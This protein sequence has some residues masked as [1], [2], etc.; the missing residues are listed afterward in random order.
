M[1][2]CI[3]STA[4]F[5]GSKLSYHKGGLSK[6]Y[7]G[8][9]VRAIC[10]L[11]AMQNAKNHLSSSIACKQGN[12]VH[13][14]QDPQVLYDLLWI[15]PAISKGLRL[16]GPSDRPSSS[17][18]SFLRD[19]WKRSC[20]SAAYCQIGKN[21][22]VE[23]RREWEGEEHLLSISISIHSYLFKTRTTDI[24]IWF[25]FC[26]VLWYSHLGI[27]QAINFWRTSFKPKLLFILINLPRAKPA[28]KAWDAKPNQAG[29]ETWD[30]FEPL[31]TCC[32][33][34]KEGW[35][36]LGSSSSTSLAQAA[37][38]SSEPPSGFSWRRSFTLSGEHPQDK[39]LAWTGWCS[40]AHSHSV[41]VTPKSFT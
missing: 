17:F 9:K 3:I 27:L 38:R 5:A 4:R 13:Y 20:H 41:T 10:L 7:D 36:Y 25:R 11:F 28:Q 39:A 30:L 37:E 26:H 15:C 1:Y 2:H 21:G 14:P 6:P 12:S 35:S 16:H 33:K 22:S 34:K 18:H 8:K 29:D 31:S 24:P 32:A 40:C 23:F 19:W